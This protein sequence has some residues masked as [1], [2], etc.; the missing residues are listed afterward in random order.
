MKTFEVYL[1][2]QIKVKINA[3]NKNDAKIL[4]EY[5]ISGGVDLSVDKERKD[6]GFQITNIKIESSDF[7]IQSCNKEMYDI[8]I[9]TGRDPNPKSNQ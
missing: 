3:E 2:R 4:S 6:Y 9:R 8:F 1:A 7:H 5:F